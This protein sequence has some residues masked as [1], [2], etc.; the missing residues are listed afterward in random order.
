MSRAGVVMV[1]VSVAVLVAICLWV[2]AA[3]HPV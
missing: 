3:P 1:V 2:L